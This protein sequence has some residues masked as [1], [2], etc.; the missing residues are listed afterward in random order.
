MPSRA[1]LIRERL[2][3]ELALA[4]NDLKKAVKSRSAFEERRAAVRV[5]VNFIVRYQSKNS[6]WHNAKI[7]DISRTGLRLQTTE[8]MLIGRELAITFGQDFPTH[9]LRIKVRITRIIH[10]SGPPFEYGVLV[11]SDAE[12]KALVAGAVL[13]ISMARKTS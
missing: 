7:N 1:E 12:T 10:Q 4:R 8:K 9:S 2:A 3:K 11:V 5:P 13:K 6:E